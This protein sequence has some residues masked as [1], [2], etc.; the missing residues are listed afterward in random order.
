MKAKDV[1]KQ[2]GLNNDYFVAWLRSSDVP[3]KVGAMGGVDIPDDQ[4]MGAIVKR[5]ESEM[6]ARQE[7]AQQQAAEQQR[8]EQE[9]LQALSNII[10]TSGF[11][12]DGYTI[13]KYSGYISGDHAIEVE[14]GT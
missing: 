5:F 10:I 8:V 14:R 1:A 12:F 7:A 4:D 2:Y 3:H 11:T 13:T 6:S 9:R